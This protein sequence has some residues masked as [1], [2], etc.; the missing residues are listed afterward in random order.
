MLA[1]PVG[2]RSITEYTPTFRFDPSSSMLEVK[3]S[4]AFRLDRRTLRLMIP[5]PVYQPD[6][7]YTVA[8]QE[9]IACAVSQISL[10]Q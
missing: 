1:V 6:L 2:R 3:R 9:R 7:Q 4:G 8:S 5:R 10:L